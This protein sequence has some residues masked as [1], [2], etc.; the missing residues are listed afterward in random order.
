MLAHRHKRP[1]CPPRP[2]GIGLRRSS[3]S[4]V[5][6]G[7]GAREGNRHAGGEIGGVRLVP[8][9]GRC[10][11]RRFGLPQLSASHNGVTKRAEKLAVQRHKGPLCRWHS[12]AVPATRV[13]SDNVWPCRCKTGPQN[14]F[15][16]RLT[17]YG[18]HATTSERWSRVALLSQS[19]ER[20]KKGSKIHSD[21]LQ[22]EAAR[23]KE[24]RF[25]RK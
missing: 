2:S 16:L 10:P 19:T 13:R 17:A 5:A 23:R 9:T 18:F 21:S 12:S 25:D 1:R 24:E 3:A 20:G 8:F 14:A 4:R 6:E 15:A 22:V 11:Q 7:E